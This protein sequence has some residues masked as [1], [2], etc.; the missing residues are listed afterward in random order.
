MS[1]FNK[2]ALLAALKPKT[3]NVPVE[4]FGDVTITQLTVD[5][6]EALRADLKKSDKVDE[7]GLRLVQASVVDSDG[8]RVFDDADLAEL[9]TS[10]NAAMD[11]LV[12][13]ALRVNGF[14]KPADAKN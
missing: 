9:K 2:S 10:S 3:Q 7:F 12:S 13:E 4:G 5:Q 6:V 8:N 1:K 11:G 14:R